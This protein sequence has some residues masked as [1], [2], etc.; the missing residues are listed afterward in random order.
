MEAGETSGNPNRDLLLARHIS[1]RDQM[2]KQKGTT[3]AYGAVV[4]MRAKRQ[5]DKGL[6]VKISDCLIGAF[7]VLTYSIINLLVL[8]VHQDFAHFVAVD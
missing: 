8:K 6:K 7:I 5:F 3:M 2:Y 4:H 1:V